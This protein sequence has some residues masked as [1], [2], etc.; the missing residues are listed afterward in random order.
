M[1][2]SKNLFANAG[3]WYSYHGS[4]TTPGCDEIVHWV[5]VQDP[6]KISLKQLRRLRRLKLG[7]FTIWIIGEIN[8]DYYDQHAVRNALLLSIKQ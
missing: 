3:P 1:S 4:L 2:L 7:R 5:V 6:L 8:A